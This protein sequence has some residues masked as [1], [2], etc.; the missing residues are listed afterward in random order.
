MKTL[1]LVL[2]VVCGFFIVKSS[3]ADSI[4]Y[5]VICENPFALAND[6]FSTEVKEAF[7]SRDGTVVIFKDGTEKRYSNNVKCIVEK[8]S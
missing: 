8:K 5:Y 1:I 2:V 7:T 4:E 3:R 6:K